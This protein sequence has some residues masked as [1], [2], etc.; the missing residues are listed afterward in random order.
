MTACL[1]LDKQTWTIH[2]VSYDT[3]TRAQ[4]AQVAYSIGQH[5]ELYDDL[6]EL[7]IHSPEQGIIF[8]DD[9]RA[10]GGLPGSLRSLETLGV[11]LPVIAVGEAPMAQRIVEAIKA[12]ALDY[13]TMPLT[14]ER[15]ERSL[16]KTGQEAESL[17]RLRRRRLE[18]QN[19]LRKLSKREAEV[20]QLLAEGCSNK[21]IAR[22]LDIS[23]RTVEIHRANM[24]AKLDAAHPASAVRI[25]LEAEHQM[26]AA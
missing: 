7:A 1:S 24:M 11:W 23:P 25:K 10:P 9:D 3:R 8:I 6:T 22:T 14:A 12:G 17:T 20:L 2:F 26:A 19:L 4:F 15:L 16:A 5:C 21:H 18:A 13:I